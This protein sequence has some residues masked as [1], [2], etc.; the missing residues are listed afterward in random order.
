MRS[1]SLKNV[2]TNRSLDLP[3]DKKKDIKLTKLPSYPNK[4]IKIEFDLDEY[5]KVDP[6]QRLERMFV[7]LSIQEREVLREDYKDHPVFLAIVDE[8]VDQV[9]AESS[10]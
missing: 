4:F 7:D 2:P 5:E 8:F 6:F 9:V 10:R 1:K 3:R